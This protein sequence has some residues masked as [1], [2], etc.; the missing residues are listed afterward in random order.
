MQPEAVRAHLEETMA[1]EESAKI[2]ET[3]HHTPAGVEPLL[4]R[5]M[6]AT[7]R[8]KKIRMSVSQGSKSYK[9]QNAEV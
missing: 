8:E 4:A 9:S 7:N 3:V 1:K 2:P 6:R 5:C